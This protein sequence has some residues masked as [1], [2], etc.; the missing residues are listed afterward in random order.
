MTSARIDPLQPLLDATV[1]A[2]EISQD[3]F[4]EAVRV[5]NVLS[6]PLTV[7]SVFDQLVLLGKVTEE[8]RHRIE[9][10][11]ENKDA[12]EVRR[13]GRY[14]M[15]N[16]IGQ[17]EF[18]VVYEAEDTASGKHY[19]LKVL[20]IKFRND[21]HYVDRFQRE[22]RIAKELKHPNIVHC[23]DYGELDGF[24]YYAMEFLTGKTLQQAI[25][26]GPIKPL[27][28]LRY[29]VEIADAL[30]HAHR[31]GI[32]HRDLKPEN[33]FLT[34][35]GTVKILDMGLS[36]DVRGVESG[37]TAKAAVGTPDYMSPEQT[38]GSAEIDGRAD[39]YSLGATFYH[40]ITG[41][42][43]YSGE[44]ARDVMMAHN[45]EPVPD[46]RNIDPDLPDDL[47]DVIMQMMEKQPK[48]RFKDAAA[49][50][51]ALIALENTRRAAKRLAKTKKQKKTSK[52]MRAANGTTSAS[53][54]VEVLEG[55]AESAKGGWS[56]WLVLILVTALAGTLVVYL[57]E[58]SPELNALL[59]PYLEPALRPVLEW[60]ATW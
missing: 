23:D 28:A 31:V 16:K 38:K 39:I 45:R 11:L 5:L 56:T 15:L 41:R 58:L 44:T 32:V 59:D 26:T 47:C 33:L 51:E 1:G 30:E 54:T 7:A 9:A 50:L 35:D 14:R 13:L 48:D 60:I 20:P 37:P 17:G 12:G 6:E 34:E 57:M 18:G 19:A 36:K 55:D 53:G 8:Q 52:K 29:M 43:P 21:P 25:R 4:A 3:D 10:R 49:L 24:L 42:V 22:G 2:G 46:P 40:L 27:I